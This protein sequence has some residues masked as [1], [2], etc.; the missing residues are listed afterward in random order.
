MAFLGVFKSTDGQPQ[1]WN[2]FKILNPVLIVML[3]FD[4]RF[5]ENIQL[6]HKFLVS[7]DFM[8]LIAGQFKDSLART[9]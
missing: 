5:S 3:V 7:L 2:K 1:S 6:L 9:L 8:T 4:L